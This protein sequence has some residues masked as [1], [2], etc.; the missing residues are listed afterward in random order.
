M[1]AG[2][3]KEGTIVE[4]DE[5]VGVV[6]EEEVDGSHQAGDKE[7]GRGKRDQNFNRSVKLVAAERHPILLACC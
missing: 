5:G 7:N 6:A 1:Q 4:E 3:D 2:G